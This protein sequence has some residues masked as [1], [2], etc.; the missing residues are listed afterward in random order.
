LKDE[1]T[2]NSRTR[3]VGKRTLGKRRG[4]HR[5]FEVSW[6]ITRREGGVLEGE[7]YI[8]RG[9]HSFLSSRSENARNDSHQSTMRDRFPYCSSS[10]YFLR[11][12][13]TWSLSDCRERWGKSRERWEIRLSKYLR[14]CTR[15]LEAAGEFEE[16]V[17]RYQRTSTRTSL[18]VR[19]VPK[20]ERI[21]E[22]K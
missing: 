12:S 14:C 16:V 11:G 7:L 21:G 4:D 8:R 5:V 19:S 18:R 15:V 10:N 2:R 13:R 1:R 22:V 9:Q 20:E 6:G 17:T 3:R